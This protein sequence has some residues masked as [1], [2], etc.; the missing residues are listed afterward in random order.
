LGKLQQRMEAQEFP[1]DDKLYLR[2]LEAHL[3]LGALCDDLHYVACRMGT[4]G[5]N[6][7][8]KPKG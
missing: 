4:W 1:R 7:M 3:R 2:V 5:S 8:P 6:G